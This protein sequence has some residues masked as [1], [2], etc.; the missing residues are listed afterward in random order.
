MR[1]LALVVGVFIAGSVIMQSD[2]TVHADT[3]KPAQINSNEVKEDIE[4]LSYHV[5]EDKI[6]FAEEID[7]EEK[8]KKAKEAEAKKERTPKHK[9]HTVKK[10]N[11]LTKI[12]KANDTTWMRLWQKNADI[13]HPDKIDIKD[14]IIIPFEDEKLEKRA[15]PEAATANEPAQSTH[16]RT[17][18]DS[19]SQR[20]TQQSTPKRS[21]HTVRS[22]DT[23]S[24]IAKANDTTWKRLWQKNTGV[25]NPDQLIVGSKIVVPFANE[26]LADRALPA[27]PAPRTTRTAPAAQ[28]TSS[29]SQTRTQGNNSR[30]Q[31]QPAVTRRAPSGGNLYTAGYCTW[32]A[33]SRRPDLPNNL[34]NAHTWATRARAQGIPTGSVPRSGAI[35]VS[36]TGPYG[37]VVYVES[38]N[39]NGTVTIS[40]MNWRGLHVTSTRTVSANSFTYIY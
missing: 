39:G 8:A 17:A 18:E 5:N 3:E 36:T 21:V 2:V 38:A 31:A 15:V 11:T 25:E 19:S 23:L 9:V 20:E 37:H 27:A 29:R 4:F 34:G 24:K 1:H 28:Q 40:E 22:G 30:P 13:E 7:S 26:E 32:Y 16:R 33:K 35:G 14:K 6:S 12:A 10:G